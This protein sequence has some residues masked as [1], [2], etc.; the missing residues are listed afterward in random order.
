MSFM[1]SQVTEKIKWL[2]I[3]GNMGVTY[4]PLRDIWTDLEKWDTMSE[5]LRLMCLQAYYE[6]T[7]SSYEVVKGYGVR[8]S[9][10]GYLDC[11]AW[12]VYPKLEQAEQ[13]ALELDAEMEL[14]YD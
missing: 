6:G 7:P 4:V 9:A 8:L 11:T 3:D 13:S 12:E 1:Q 2:A 14:L 10:P 5:T